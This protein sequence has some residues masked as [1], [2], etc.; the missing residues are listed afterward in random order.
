LAVFEGISPLPQLSGKFLQY[1]VAAAVLVSLGW[2][3][4]TVHY[5]GRLAEQASV[6]QRMST[7]ATETRPIEQEQN[8]PRP[9]SVIAT[10][11]LS[12]EIPTVRGTGSA[13][14]PIVT[15]AP[16]DSLVMLHLSIPQS[17]GSFRATL[18]SFLDEQELLQENQ[19][20]PVKTER[21]PVVSFP[22]PSSLVTDGTD[23]LI[24][25]S[26]LDKTGKTTPV[27]RFLFKVRK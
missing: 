5:K 4:A 3:A 27:S 14:E 21:G 1:A 13:Q 25:L 17:T 24:T 12:S 26:A 8:P 10:Y 9:N 22:L 19:L 16:G 15:F 6:A 7:Q 20:K 23:Y 2:L 18:S 11:F